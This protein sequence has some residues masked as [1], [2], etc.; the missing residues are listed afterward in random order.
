[1]ADSVTDDVFRTPEGGWRISGTRVSLDSIVYGYL[2]G[3]TPES[4]AEDFPSLTLAQVYAGLAFYLKHRDEIDGH[5][6]LQQSRWEQLR[7]QS[8]T[9]HSPLLSRLRA[10]R[11]EPDRPEGAA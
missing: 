10:R 1:M 8:Q 3:E 4:I 9:A 2:E 5:L 11:E 6:A 7:Q